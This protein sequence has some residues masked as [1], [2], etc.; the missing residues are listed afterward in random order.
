METFSLSV[1]GMEM[2]VESLKGI[3]HKSAPSYYSCSLSATVRAARR[4]GRGVA[5]RSGVKQSIGFMLLSFR[6]KK[7]LP[8]QFRGLALRE[9]EPQRTSA[10]LD[11]ASIVTEHPLKRRN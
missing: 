7:L 8:R 2:D 4:V 11:K 10:Q 1:D 5:W 9:P 3:V 6:G